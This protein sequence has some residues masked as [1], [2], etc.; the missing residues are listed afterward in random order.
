MEGVPMIARALLAL[1]NGK[2]LWRGFAVLLLA[3]AGWPPLATAADCVPPACATSGGIQVTVQQFRSGNRDADHWAQ[4]N[5]R[6]VN[7]GRVP[8]TLGYVDD[9]GQLLDEN[10]NI[11][12]VTR[13]GARGIGLINRSAV[14]TSFVLQPGESADARFEFQWMRGPQNVTGL[15]FQMSLALRELAVQPGGQ[16]RLGREHLLRWSNLADGAGAGAGAVA[17]A[18][19]AATP[20]A[21]PIPP[22]VTAAPSGDLCA[23]RSACQASGAFTT[24][25]VRVSSPAKTTYANELLVTVGF[26]VTNHGAAPLVL[27][28]VADS[29]QML[30]EYGERY[31]VTYV[32]SGRVAGI[33]LVRRGSGVDPQFAL[34]PGESRAFTL[35]YS[36]IGAPNGARSYSVDLVL[37]QLELLP[38]NQVRIARENSISFPQL[39]GGGPA[40]GGG[41]AGAPAAPADAAQAIQELRNLF[42]KK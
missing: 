10:G 30:D 13:G 36:R 15:Q 41:S 4:A 6:I 32:Y 7:A 16:V 14:D 24:D 39:A 42:R 2:S 40:G 35:G 34:Q 26:R 37:A 28:F 21:A 22:A 17:A 12:R 11:Y 29:G 20:P 8:M 5:L 1:S 25:V 19:A 33:G 31:K 23:G 18:P 9:S 38:G 3:A 27:G